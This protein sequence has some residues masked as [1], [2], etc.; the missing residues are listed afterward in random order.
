MLITNQ[1]LLSY[2][3]CLIIILLCLFDETKANVYKL[4]EEN[5]I[6]FIDGP[7]NKIVKFYGK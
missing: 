2:L 5:F 3:L 6:D 7:H 1:N 4:T